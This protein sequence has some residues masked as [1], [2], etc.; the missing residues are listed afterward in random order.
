M[1]ENENIRSQP[2]L[3][4]KTRFKL[5]I[6]A[7]A[8]N[9]YIRRDGT[10]NRRILSFIDVKASARATRFINTTR[11]STSDIS[12]DLSRTLWFRLFVPKNGIDSDKLLPLIVYFHG[13][14]FT[15]YGPDSKS[16]DNLC[17]HLAAKV[18]A[19]VVSVNYRLAPEH[20]Y[21]SQ[22][23]DGFDALKFIDAQKDGVLPAN[24]NF[25]NCF[26]GG[27]SAGGNIAHHVTVRA[28]ENS[29]QFEKIRITGILLLQ[30][31]FGGEERTESELRLI[32]APM[33]DVKRTDLMWR[34]FLPTDADRNHPAANV[35]GG[36]VNSE[37]AAALKNLDFPSTLVIMGG[38]DP[39]HDWQR[40]YVGG[41]KNCEK[42]V[43]LIE[44][45]NAFHGFYAFPE[46]PE[47]GLLIDNVK[48]FIQK[49]AHSN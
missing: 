4:I 22:Y 10:I 19:V 46:V 44:Y 37:A 49:Q 9:F 20:K 28:L 16:F 33:I 8:R 13:G 47:F 29:N 3:P 18:P 17:S 36:G 42:Q 6:L 41:L 31:F 15:N 1:A 23:D 25:K 45:P 24:T 11:V 43:E 12:V 7:L 26:V 14:G 30:P 34:N 27:D 40:R 21:P 5:H 2:E 32:N 39:L 38:N 48:N 35:F